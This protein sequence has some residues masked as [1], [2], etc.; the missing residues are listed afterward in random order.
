[1]W[2]VK[3][4]IE[5]KWLI[6]MIL[7]LLYQ[8]PNSLLDGDLTTESFYPTDSLTIPNIVHGILM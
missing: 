6:G 3:W 8:P 4:Q 2:L 7:L 1:M 5:K